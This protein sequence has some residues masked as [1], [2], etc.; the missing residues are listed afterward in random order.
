MFI[1]TQLFFVCSLFIII[2]CN[3]SSSQSANK[4]NNSK[5]TLIIKSSDYYLDYLDNDVVEYKLNDDSK[6]A[7]LYM[8]KDDS[9]IKELLPLKNGYL[10]GTYKYYYPDGN[11]ANEV[12]YSNGLKNGEDTFYYRSGKIKRKSEYVK[13]T[14]NGKSIEYREDGSIYIESEK[15][16]GKSHLKMFDHGKLVS[17]EYDIDYNGQNLGISKV[18]DA[19]GNLR[20][21]IGFIMVDNVMKDDVLYILD[22][23]DSVL[24]SINPKEDKLKALQLM[25]TVGKGF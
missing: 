8:V 14:L 23:N 11:L 10:N 18:Y 7:G 21:S 2:S 5:D 19:S 3:S 17:E 13:N 25:M 20:I 15:I 9:I 16:D 6:M 4:K 12:S 24:D 1:R 22:K